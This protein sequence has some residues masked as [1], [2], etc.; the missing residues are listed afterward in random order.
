IV[1]T[2]VGKD[3]TEKVLR[4]DL[5]LFRRK[6][7]AFGHH[8]TQCTGTIHCAICIKEHLTH[9]H[10]CSRSQYPTRGKVNNYNKPH[11]ATSNECTTYINAQ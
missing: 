10:S 3:A 11:P 2:L 9:L 1:I 7:L 4:S 5:S 8:P 6:C